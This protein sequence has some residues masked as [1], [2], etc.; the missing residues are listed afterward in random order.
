MSCWL[1]ESRR[2]RNVATRCLLDIVIVVGPDSFPGSSSF[3]EAGAFAS[4]D[5]PFL[6]STFFRPN[7][8]ALT[9]ELPIPLLPRLHITRSAAR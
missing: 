6:A 3:G 4:D 5:A 2:L 9:I 8:F 1:T 7:F